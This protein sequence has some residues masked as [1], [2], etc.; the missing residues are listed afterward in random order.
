M[1]L[2]LDALTLHP[3][4]RDA[5]NSWTAQAFA[6]L[7]AAQRLRQSYAERLQWA[8][9]EYGDITGPPI[10]GCYGEHFPDTVKDA[11]RTRAREI[12][13]ATDRAVVC[14]RRSGRKLRTLQ[15]YMELA[16]MLDDNRRSYY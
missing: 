6:A 1:N 4:R 13:C 9:S 10:S 7:L 12:G 14:W 11:L 5:D 8:I 16:R 2:S 15:P 3:T